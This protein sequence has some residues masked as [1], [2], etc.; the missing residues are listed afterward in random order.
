MALGDLSEKQLLG[1]TA[2]VVGAVLLVVAGILLWMYMRYRN[3][4]DEIRM[5]D[6]KA[7]TMEAKAKELDGLQKV[8][9]EAMTRFHE[10]LKRVP[11]E[12]QTSDLD[13][14]ISEQAANAKLRILKLELVQERSRGKKTAKTGSL[15]KIRISIQATGSFNAFG[16]FLNNIEQNMDRFVAVTGFK[17]TA[18]EDGLVPGNGGHEIEIDLVTYRYAGGKTP[19]KAGSPA[20]ARR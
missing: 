13:A 3:L 9:D 14:Q 18:F 20:T 2:A 10:V 12:S 6:A 8:H 5:K 1:L 17:I 16:Q 7:S 15:E 11:D 4:M 19:A